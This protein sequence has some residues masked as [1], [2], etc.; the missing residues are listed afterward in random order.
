MRRGVHPRVGGGNW[1]RE[2]GAELGS[3]PSPR[4]RGKRR[5]GRRRQARY[6]SIPAWAGETLGRRGAP[7]P[8]EV[9]PRVGGG[10]G[11]QTDVVLPC[12]GPS[13]RGRGKPD[14]DGHGSADDGSIP[15]WAG[16]TN[17]SSSPPLR[18]G[19]HPRVGGGNAEFVRDR[20][21][22]K[23]PS[24]RGRGKRRRARAAAHTRWVHPRVGGG[25]ANS[26]ARV[27]GAGGPS[28]RGRGKPGCVSS[29]ITS[30]RS[31]P[32]WAGETDAA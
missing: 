15:A 30:R 6:G 1:A 31:I 26:A 24:P 21:L 32:A 22:M 17:A 10:N 25:N 20:Q 4:G 12:G 3:G 19:V 29:Q 23:G 28:P 5:A 14:D 9:H 2:A 13:P 27:S 8:R 11:G 18:R 16:E 7:R